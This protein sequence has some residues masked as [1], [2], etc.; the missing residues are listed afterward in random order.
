[1]NN[2]IFFLFIGLLP[3]ISSNYFVYTNFINSFLIYVLFIFIPLF[4]IH[5]HIREKSLIDL[6][7]WIYILVF[8]GFAFFFQSNNNIFPWLDFKID[9]AL[10]VKTIIIYTIGIISYIIGRYFSQKSSILQSRDLS[11]TRLNYLLYFSLILILLVIFTVG[12]KSFLL[13]RVVFTGQVQNQ[14]SSFLILILRFLQISLP[15][16]IILYYQKYLKKQVSIFKLIF[17]ISVTLLYFNPIRSSRLDFL[18]VMSILFIYIIK[19]HSKIWAYSLIIGVCFIFPLADIFRSFQMY[20]PSIFDLN[21]LFTTG[22]Y[23]GPTTIIA[24]LIYLKSNSFLYG[25]NFITAIFSYVPRSIWT[26]KLYGSGF[27]LTDSLGLN[28][29]NIGVNM[30][31]ESNLSFGIFGVIIFFYLIGRFISI[32]NSNY[33]SDYFTFII[34]LYTTAGMIFILRGELMQVGLKLVPL[35]IISFLITKKAGQTSMI[36]TIDI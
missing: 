21:K 11:I 17:T 3:I 2:K 9:N 26:G 4:F 1:M 5:K 25:E 20:V 35:I 14:S 23:D 33:R 13:P 6:S 10:I 24:S 8:V 12:I 29:P 31:A 36:K 18:L 30:W 32:L 19:F 15:I 16:C 7:F 28:Y 22:D 34:Y 27:I